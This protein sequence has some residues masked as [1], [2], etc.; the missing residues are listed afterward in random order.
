MAFWTGGVAVALGAA[1][2]G[3]MLKPIGP[4]FAGTA[5]EADPEGATALSSLDERAPDATAAKQAP[6]TTEI[7]LFCDGPQ[8]AQVPASV[9]EARI[10][11]QFCLKNAPASE[12]SSVIAN[13]ANGFAATL[14]FPKAKAF[15][16]DY[17]SLSPGR[18]RISIAHKWPGGLVETREFSIERALR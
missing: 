3:F 11:G 18:N 15:T 6:Q 13:E 5:S 9:K 8:S 10:S 7:S 1:V 12:P 16:T 2:C 14:F 4:T 17:I